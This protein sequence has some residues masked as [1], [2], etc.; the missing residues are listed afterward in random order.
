MHADLK[1]AG[2]PTEIFRYPAA[3]HGF[4]LMAGQLRAGEK[5]IDQL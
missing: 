2:V 3:I 5:A 1:K 4:F